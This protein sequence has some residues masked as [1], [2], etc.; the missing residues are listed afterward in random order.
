MRREE[1]NCNV[2]LLLLIK[3]IL[4]DQM[5][6]MQSVVYTEICHKEGA[7][8]F[9]ECQTQDHYTGC[10]KSLGHILTLN[11][12]KTIK[13]ITMHLIYSESLQFQVFL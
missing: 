12:L 13:E 9:Q 7:W 4:R 3:A 6:R 11:I 2:H 1:M 5:E 10:P 8:F